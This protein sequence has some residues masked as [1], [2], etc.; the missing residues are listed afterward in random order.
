MSE[1]RATWDQYFLDIATAAAA[2]STCPRRSVG[3]II[4]RDKIILSTGY[5][6][7]VSAAPHCTAKGCILVDDHCVA[8]VHAEANAIVQA[9]KTGVQLAYATIYVTS[10]PCLNCFKLIVNAGIKRIVYKEEYKHVDYRILN[11]SNNTFPEIIGPGWTSL[12]NDLER[13]SH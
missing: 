3:S 2:R 1:T 6:G 13:G 10:N 8:T 12:Q 5:N 4:A 9:C 7:S 11:M